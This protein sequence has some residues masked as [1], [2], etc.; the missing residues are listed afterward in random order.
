MIGFQ[1]AYP[2]LFAVSGFKKSSGFF[3]ERSQFQF[4][5]VV[6]DQIVVIRLGFGSHAD[7]DDVAD[8]DL[9]RSPVE[10]GVVHIEEKIQ[11][12]FGLE[13][14]AAVEFGTDDLV[15][16]DQI[17]LDQFKVEFADFFHPD[18]FRQ[19][20]MEGLD[21]V[22][23]GIET[24]YGAEYRM[25]LQHFVHC[26]R[27]LI[28]GEKRFVHLDHGEEIVH[29]RDRSV[30]LI[31]HHEIL[32]GGQPVGELFGFFILHGKIIAVV[33]GVIRQIDRGDL[34]R[35]S[36]AVD[37]GCV[38]PFQTGGNDDLH[39]AEGVAAE[40]IEVVFDSDALEFERLRHGL[41]ELFFRRIGRSDIVAD[42]IRSV[43]SGEC[44]AVEF[45]GR[46]ERHFVDFDEILRQHV[47]RQPPGECFAGFCRIGLG[48]VGGVVGG[49]ECLI[50]L[51]ES[52]HRTPVQI[53]HLFHGGFDFGGLHTVSVD[54][55]HIGIAAEQNIVA[56]REFLCQVAGMIDPVLKGTR[57]FFREVDIAPDKRI[58]ETE[59]AGLAVRDLLPVFA[60]QVDFLVELRRA[61]GTGIVTA[62]DP[63]DAGGK[64]AFAHGIAVVDLQFAG[65][66][67]VCRFR[68]DEKPFEEGTG[69][70]SDSA[71]V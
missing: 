51:L 36:A 67:A 21:D 62:V 7:I 15:W 49:E 69:F 45:P 28:R 4:L 9:E 43:R 3:I 54:L 37:I 23:V 24:E 71:D 22:S 68:A 26:R 44:L 61:D 34:F 58:V 6:E 30:E 16:L 63:E 70:G 13:E 1:T 11:R 18:L 55:H 64:A 52:A 19:F 56:V 33:A 53:Q 42:V 57:R 50:I 12:L 48:D 10:N 8:Q 66:D 38:Q 2:V 65:A 20:G 35:R 29:G 40:F 5:P 27:Q 25:M 47:V 32:F 14:A 60:K 59:F 31:I 46:F 39:G 41:A 17:V